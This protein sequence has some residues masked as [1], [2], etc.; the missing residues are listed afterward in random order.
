MEM[1]FSVLSLE[2]APYSSTP[3]MTSVRENFASSSSVSSLDHWLSSARRRLSLQTDDYVR[4]I[5]LIIMH[6]LSTMEPENIIC[7]C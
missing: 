4:R 5:Q 3:R 6:A 1:G 2:T 7:L